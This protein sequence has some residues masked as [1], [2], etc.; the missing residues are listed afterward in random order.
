MTC[1]WAI[2]SCFGELLIAREVALR[3]TQ[4]RLILGQLP[5]RL[6]QCRLVRARIDL[7]DEVARLDRLAFGEANAL[8]VPAIWV[9]MVTVSN[10]VTV[11]KASMVSGM[12][13]VMTDATRTV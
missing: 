12:S 2:E 3:L 1:C 13:P 9:R 7:G 8:N 11:P 4:Q 6:G 10:G 5:L